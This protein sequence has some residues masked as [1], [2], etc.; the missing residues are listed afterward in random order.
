[1]TRTMEIEVM[2][3]TTGKA[4]MGTRPT[5]SLHGRSMAEDGIE[6]IATYVMSSASDMHAA[7]SKADAEIG[8]VKS[9]NIM[10]KGTMIIMVHTMTNLTGSGHQKRDTS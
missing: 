5:P 2:M 3:V 10:M 4:F 1:M 9:K 8:R 6:T 7:E